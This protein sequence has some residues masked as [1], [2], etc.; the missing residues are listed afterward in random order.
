M[1]SCC[2]YQAEY[3]ARGPLL[4]SSLIKILQ[5]R[6]LPGRSICS[7]KGEAET[8]Q[9]SPSSPRP[10]HTPVCKCGRERSHRVLQAQRQPQPTPQGGLKLKWSITG[11]WHWAEVA[12]CLFY[13]SMDQSL[14]VGHLEKGDLRQGGSGR[15]GQVPKRPMAVDR[16]L[17]ALLPWGDLGGGPST[18][19]R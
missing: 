17:S 16:L 11:Q 10:L 8:F 12:R 1:S 5:N 14:D 15:L 4:F 18:P 6:G 13:P 19:H 9:A 3:L 7:L 2:E